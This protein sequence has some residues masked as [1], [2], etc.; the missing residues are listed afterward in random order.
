[1][2]PYLKNHL[3]NFQEKCMASDSLLNVIQ[4]LVKREDR[5]SK[6]EDKITKEKLK[7]EKEKEDDEED[8]EEPAPVVGY[9]GDDSEEDEDEAPVGDPD[10]P[11]TEADPEAEAD[12]EGEEE[13]APEPGA[14]PE[15]E[16][17]AEPD[18]GAGDT[19]P[20]GPDPV[21]VQQVT[22]AV[23]GQIMQMMKDAEAEHKEAN[24]K[25]IKLSGKKEK[26]DTK[27]KMESRKSFRE[28]IRLSVT[29]GTPLSEDYEEDVLNILENEGIDGPLGY[30]PFFEKGKLFVEKGSEKSAAKVLKKSR[31]IRKVPKIVGESLE[32]ED[33][34]E[35][36][37]A[38]VSVMLKKFGV[39]SP[40]ELEGDKKKAYF[41][42]LDK[43]W[44]AEGEEPE[45]GDKKKN[46]NL[47]KQVTKNVLKEASVDSFVGA[48]AVGGGL[49]AMKKAWDKWGKTSKLAKLINKKKYAD[50][51]VSKDKEDEID[52][53]NQ[54]AVDKKDR[55]AEF[56]TNDDAQAD[57][58]Q[59]IKDVGPEKAKSM[60]AKGYSLD[61]EDDTK[62][63]PSKE[64]S[65]KD[66]AM[67]SK[68][69][70]TTKRQAGL[71]K[72]MTPDE[73]AAKKDKAK[74]SIAK[75]K[76]KKAGNE[77]FYMLAKEELISFTEE[78]KTQLL[79]EL[80]SEKILTITERNELQGVKMT[81]P[82]IEEAYF[83]VDIA[84]MPS[85]YIEGG[86]EGTVKKSLRGIVK[87]DAIK[88]MK[89]VKVKKGE[90]LKTF[91]ADMKEEAAELNEKGTAYPA[92]IDTLKMIVKDKQNQVVMFKSGSARVDS[93]TASAMVQVYDA[94]KPK[95]KK[96][97]EKMI[98]DKAGFLKSQ[99]FAMKMTEETFAGFVENVD[100]EFVKLKESNELQA[101]MA[102][103]DVGIKA[104]INRKGQLTVKKRDLKKAEKALGK[105][106]KRGGEPDIYVENKVR[107]AYDIVSKARAKLTEAY[108]THAAND[109]RM[110]IDND[111]QLYRQQTTSI[112]KNVQRK[113]K[114]GKYDH[115]KAPKLWSYLVD[116]GVKKYIK[117]F[118]GNAKD[119]FPKD[120]R[121]SVAIELADYY[122]AEIEAQGGEMM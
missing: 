65:A 119:L 64:A 61:P 77:E 84:G 95:S 39:E 99:A 24:K 12:P 10:E 5:I 106:F 54:D 90:M 1:M 68:K 97:F 108:D 94:L 4:G 48:L 75:M 88:T 51:V 78:D 7:L 28:S 47:E 14:E 29:S 87:N 19:K 72:K 80:V 9:A 98:K 49:W 114:S 120:V 103:D 27:P 17:E 110:Y 22:N 11:E 109:L 8:E 25:E 113:L 15:A 13:P 107:S 100:G 30:E 36:Y 79:K 91:K 21:L 116:N 6:K 57:Y 73:V 92:T 62:V 86:G 101:I 82:N 63:M 23:M 112:I 16:P 71:N 31:D 33:K 35:K 56:G 111:R 59:D 20:N 105:S 18:D 115:T 118:G 42:A 58:D 76:A 66:K 45:P 117:E 104:E 3:Q 41:D 32:E 60:I 50:D 89:V 34:K 37:Q 52:K 43:G 40:A 67:K 46:E 55:E 122:K 93:F 74:K 96:T 83:K 70:A 53:D 26:I 38:F 102:L 121:Q 69:S 44:D 2:T 81:E 85:I